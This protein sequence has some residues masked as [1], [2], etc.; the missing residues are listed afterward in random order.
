MPTLRSFL[1]RIS[2]MFRRGRRDV[3]FSTELDAHLQSHID[4]NVRTGMTLDDARR[5]AL[6]KLGGRAAASEAWRDRRGLPFVESFAQDARFALRALRRNPGF[7]TGATTTLAVG[8]GAVTIMFAVVSGGLLTPVPYPQPDRLVRLQERT[9]RP[10]QFGNLWAFSYPNFPRLPSRR[11]NVD[12]G[13]VATKRRN[14]Q[15]ARTCG[16]RRRAPGLARIVW[17]SRRPRT[18]RDGFRR[19]RGSAVR[20]AC[21]NHQP[22]HVAEPFS[23]RQC[24]RTATHLQRGR[25]HGCRRHGAGLRLLR[26]CLHA[27]RAG[28]RA[29]YAGPAGSSGHSGVAR[30]RRIG[31]STLRKPSCR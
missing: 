24:D 23:G 11:T 7:A 10:T 8:I 26:R 16:L 15:L 19:R 29:L 27:D 3:E 4:D 5:D 14:R 9:G 21:R 20:R 31:R 2:R 22:P 30:L 1:L 6:L 18:R 12:D 25:I 13:R 17:N 28:E